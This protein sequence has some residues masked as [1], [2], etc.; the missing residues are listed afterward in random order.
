MS[1]FDTI[2]EYIKQKENA[3]VNKDAQLLAKIYIEK[4]KEACFKEIHNIGISKKLKDFEVVV[5]SEKV[6]TILINNGV[7]LKKQ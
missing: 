3:P 1:D 4:G 7:I 2:E 5:L 6:R